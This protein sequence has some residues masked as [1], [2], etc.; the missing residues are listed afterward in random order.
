VG[1][2]GRVTTADYVQVGRYAAG[3]DTI[4]LS[5]FQVADCAPRSTLGDGRISTADWVQAGR[6]ALGVDDP[7]PCGGPDA[8]IVLRPSRLDEAPA[9]DGRA[10]SV[11]GV[12]ALPGSEVT[13]PV[14]LAAKGN[15]NALSFTVLFDPARMTFKGA[16]PGTG[17][18]SSIVNTNEASAG[19]VGILMGLPIGQASAVGDR[20]V[21]LLNF[22]VAADAA[23]TTL[24]S[25]A[26]QPTSK[27]VD[28]A[29]AETLS[30][31]Y[32]AGTVVFAAAPNPTVAVTLSA[33][34]LVLSW[35]S[36]AQGFELESSEDLNSGWTKV[37][38]TPQLVGDRY[39][40]TLP[41]PAALQ[42]FYR[43]HK[44]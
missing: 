4:P 5:E 19:K 24:V 13:L 7:A 16:T 31:D 26:D 14:R 8:A 12:N 27:E 1:G 10:V 38:E 18:T 11:T 41:Q 23:G 17:W 3:L 2:D 40:V 22:S 20:D 43:L 42:Q 6:Y 33:G 39:V 29:S 44:P 9:S 28:D 32:I 25:F 30:A 35:G 21:V 15:E 37:L 34:N 36:D